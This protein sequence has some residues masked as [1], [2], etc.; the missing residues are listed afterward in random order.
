MATDPVCGMYVDERSAELTLARDNRTYYFC[1]QSCLAE[2]QDPAASRRRLGRELALAGGLTVLVVLL[3]DASGARTALLAAAVLAGIV[4]FGPGRVFY[5][6]TW[7]ALRSRVANMDVLIAVGT[8]A[9]YGYGLAVL[10]VPGPLPPA[11]YFDASSLIITLI[12]AG[13]YLER[14]V[15]ER[16]T[17]AVGALAR[18]LPARAHRLGPGG[19][20]EVAVEELRAG[21]PLRVRGGER[22]P[23]DGLVRAGRSEADEATLTGESLP[24]PKG[25]G[26]HV[27]AGSLNGSG[28]VEIVVE[29]LGE[30][31]LLGQVGELLRAAEGEPVP[32]RRLADRLAS[33]FVPAVL[34]LAILAALAWGTLGGAPLAVALLIFVSVAIT[35]CPC[36][37]GLATPAALL[38]GSSTA[39]ERGILYRGGRTLERAARVD[40]VI[41][42]KTGTLT[43]GRPR[44]VRVVEA[45][46][47]VQ[48]DALALAAGLETGS[49]HPLA[50]AV[51]SAARDRGLPLTPCS[52]VIEEPG[53]GVRGRSGTSAVTLERGGSVDDPELAPLFSEGD[54]RAAVNG[55]TFSVLRVDGSVVAA[56]IFEDE[57]LPGAREAVRA[58]RSQGLAVEVA[59]GDREAAVGRLAR[60]LGIDRHTSGL[61]PAA[62]LELLRTRRE[63][64]HVVAFVGDGVND[65]PALAA[66][67]VGIAVGTG[68]EVAHRAGRVLL[69]RPG[70]EGV[71][72][73]LSIARRTV[74]KVRQNLAWAVGYN[75]VLLPLAAGALVAE[76]GFGVYRW[77]PITGALAMALSSTLVLAN[78][79]SLRLLPSPAGAARRRP[80]P[81]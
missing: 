36:A 62:K 11:E 15:R 70:L 57:P 41:F 42:D 4:Q 46:G 6:G 72:L 66:A 26:D 67:D 44:L 71:G 52:D 43:S 40:W 33:V 19:E 3:V 35:A 65:A 61:T 51:R 29:R 21:D 50:Q 80:A 23:V 45:P 8:T 30:A 34:L 79:L 14:R 78:S 2:F 37:F 69:V 75:L 27:L 13:N 53:L 58:L 18:L 5:R 24:V 54:D 76:F 16:A 68:A 39:A 25:P 56:L 20:Q 60:E 47:A 59:S 81:G 28:T 9:S 31:T 10:L 63:E 17:S 38:V 12:L 77:L 7:D 48:A 73:A 32:L 74:A 22:F 55:R 1:A 49:N 64:G